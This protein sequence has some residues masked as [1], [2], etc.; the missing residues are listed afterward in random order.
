VHLREIGAELSGH[1][2]TIATWLRHTIKPK[3][4]PPAEPWATVV[5]DPKM[6]AVRLTGRLRNKETRTLVLVVHG[7]GGEIEN[8]YMVEAA[9]AAEAAGM[10]C[11]RLSL[12]GADRSGEDFYHAGLTADLHAALS[13]R[14]VA[15]YEKVFV[16]GYSLGGHVTLRYGLDGPDKRVAAI[17]AISAPLDLDL[18]AR[19]FDRP[20]AEPYR[21]HVL[22]DLSEIYENVARR[23]L[24]PLPVA[25]ARHIRKIREWDN[26]IV[27][28]RYGF[29]D[30]EHYYRSVSVAPWLPELLLPSLLLYARN[31]PMVPAHTVSDATARCGPKTTLKWIERGGHMGFPSQLDLGFGR[32]LG[33]EA[34]VLSWLANH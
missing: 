28:P 30:A 20:I 22:S 29:R 10:A 18:C 24:V 16:L 26:R 3:L 11:L 33:L 9:L 14:E 6:G 13:S 31:D 8:S 17:A 5:E 2:W 34:Q 19:A 25:E 1:G 32:V 27:A 15:R 21:R 7:L 23:R 4:A 12:R